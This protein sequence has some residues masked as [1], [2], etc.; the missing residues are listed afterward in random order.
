MGAKRIDELPGIKQARKII[1]DERVQNIPG[2]SKVYNSKPVSEAREYTHMPARVV[3]LAIFT[4]I[5][6]FVLMFLFPIGT[7]IGAVM[8][9]MAA[10]LLTRKKWI[11]YFA[12]V[13]YVATIAYAA[14]N[15]VFNMFYLAAV[16]I[17]MNIFSIRYL[18]DPVIREHFRFKTRAEK[19]AEKMAKKEL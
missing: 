15:I 5:A 17:V 7:V 16:T 12:L 3:F 18:Y 8:M 1:K 4:S 9:L 14:Y 13:F 11:W 6:G 19:K 10:A 2:V